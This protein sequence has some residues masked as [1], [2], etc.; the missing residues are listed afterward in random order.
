M[1]NAQST[2]SIGYND[3]GETI[4]HLITNQSFYGSRHFAVVVC[5]EVLKEMNPIIY[6]IWMSIS[7]LKGLVPRDDCSSSARV[8]RVFSHG[9]GLGQFSCFR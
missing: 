9:V 5:R 3:Q 8:K 4:L 2:V 7:V 1:F 6:L